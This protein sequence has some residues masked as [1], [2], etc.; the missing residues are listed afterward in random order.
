MLAETVLRQQIS[1]VIRD[2]GDDYFARGRVRSLNDLGEG[3]LHAHVEGARVYEVDLALEDEDLLVVRCDCRY[4]EDH[5]EACKH[6]WAAIRAASVRNLLPEKRLALVC[7]EPE[8]V[9][10]AVPAKTRPP[11]RLVPQ[12]RAWER[13][14]DAVGRAPAMRTATRPVPEQIAYVLKRSSSQNVIAIHIL[15]RSRK[16]GGDWGKW[17]Q[18]ALD[19]TDLAALDP[20]DR[21][22]LSLLALRHGVAIDAMTTV[23]GPMIAWWIERLARAGRLFVDDSA[24]DL[25]PLT[26]DDGPPWKLR[27]AIVS[28]DARKAYRIDGAIERDGEFRGQDRR[29]A[30][31]GFLN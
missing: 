22:T 1:R 5:V 30:L 15:G 10:E 9:E 12:P 14:L 23:P 25:H 29:F 21:E 18:V 24:G 20:F 11:L 7:D 28:D 8:W 4:Y 2:R 17:K 13:F 27:V 19:V 16:K 6:I 26:W 31:Y 3:V